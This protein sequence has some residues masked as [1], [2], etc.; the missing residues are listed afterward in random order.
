MH[1]EHH[2]ETHVD[3]PDD[4]DDMH[5]ERH[6]EPRS[7]MYTRLKDQPRRRVESSISH[8]PW[9]TFKKNKKRNHP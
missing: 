7:N 1:E 2:E 8:T 3:E 6:E 9:T 5:E 4:D